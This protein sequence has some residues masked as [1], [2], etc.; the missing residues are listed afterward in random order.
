MC[1]PNRV[2]QPK[3][4]AV[5]I[6]KTFDLNVIH[7]H[8]ARQER[9]VL[10]NSQN[11]T[12][13]IQSQNLNGSTLATFS[14]YE[15]GQVGSNFEIRLQDASF[16][17]LQADPYAK[18]VTFGLNVFCSSNLDVLSNIS[19]S[20]ARIDDAFIGKVS[21]SN[22]VLH[23]DPAS[24]AATEHFRIDTGPTT[25]ILSIA[26]DMGYFLADGGNFKFG[27]GT[28]QPTEQLHVRYNGIV[29]G[30]LSNAGQIIT[31]KI[32]NYANQTSSIEFFASSNRV[33]GNTTFTGDILVQGS[34]KLTSKQ[35]FADVRVDCNFEAMHMHISNI[36][37]HLSP[38]IRVD[39]VIPTYMLNNVATACN[40]EAIIDIDVD[41]P[42]LEVS[43][44]ALTMD[45][46]GRIGMGTTK[47]EYFL[48][49]EANAYNQAYIGN[50][51]IYAKSSLNTDVPYCDDVFIVDR[52]ANVGIGT[53]L[54]FHNLHVD[55]CKNDS[56]SK[57]IVGLYKNDTHTCPFL[58]CTN[59]NAA[60]VSVIDRNGALFIGAG[61]SNT[62]LLKAP[63]SNVMC[64]INGALY[65]QGKIITSGLAST[66]GTRVID[67]NA[68]YLSNVENIDSSNITTNYCKASNINAVSIISEN[69]TI[70]G[71][72]I[73]T[74]AFRVLETLDKFI[75]NG[76][77]ALYSPDISTLPALP[78]TNGIY[79]TEAQG[80]VQI[81]APLS[82]FTSI[83]TISNTYL[84]KLEGPSPTLSLRNTRSAANGG[85]TSSAQLRF[86]YDKDATT[87]VRGAINFM[88]GGFYMLHDTVSS[89]T[90]KRDHYNIM[91]GA[92]GVYTNT[93][94]GLANMRV[95]YIN[96]NI[97]VANT[98]DATMR[99]TLKITQGAYVSGDVY[100][101]GV[102]SS[103][104]GIG[105]VA[106]SGGVVTQLTG[107]TTA[108]TLNKLTGQITLFTTTLAA[109]TA[110]SFI[111]NNN[112]IVAND[113]VIVTQV[114]GTVALYNCQAVAAAGSA[115]IS[116]RNP[117]A[118]ISAS[119]APVL[120]FT[121]L[122]SVIA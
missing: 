29:E 82:Q 92:L 87:T 42:N 48:S 43:Y 1:I 103:A 41:I 73:T 12:T 121:V 122:K 32:V 37:P 108:V 60:P 25:P 117:T 52:S 4:M 115:T 2:S 74:D 75:F 116:I 31:P 111:L 91:T 113:H 120:K 83:S 68:S 109:N 99:S 38:S 6:G 94:V 65:A 44:R 45:S 33:S 7:D 56:Q 102:T 81:T 114:G 89:M 63:T 13:L 57:A 50:G 78:T 98:T 112:T 3:Q 88:D 61:M 96:T 100:A 80:K 86:I 118:T 17:I 93:T 110:Q 22:Y 69:I 119:E 72:S 40:T 35:S 10:V 20:S 106:G 59:S 47:P 84:L 105:Y 67:M 54:P 51:L 9:L 70:P 14:N 28:T 30:T 79:T 46:Y 36:E 49:L 104:G 15:I 58:E 19:A 77:V 101:T 107:R 5:V 8:V 11:D 76:K 53:A 23:V 71:L 85:A 21:A 97:D 66:L 27:I 16:P 18:T 26:K 39:H 24:F 95:A 62:I 55:V 34:F 64:G 90:F